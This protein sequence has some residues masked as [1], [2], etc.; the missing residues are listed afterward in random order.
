MG[1]S[2]IFC[3]EKWG[4]S[5]KR[6][7]TSF[8]TRNEPKMKLFDFG[9][10]Q[11]KMHMASREK[12]IFHMLFG[13][14][15]DTPRSFTKLKAKSIFNCILTYFSIRFKLFLIKKRASDIC[16]QLLKMVIFIQIIGLLERITLEMG[17]PAK[18]ES[19]LAKQ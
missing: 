19:I 7:V 5:K 1:I 14:F 13:A 3:I 4:I 16:K 6:H 11:N 8:K 12:Y 10:F 2:N 15:H 9:A 18:P 17:Y